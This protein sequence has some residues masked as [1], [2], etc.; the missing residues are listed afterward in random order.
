MND[1]F[2][3][4][5]RSNPGV[6]E[7]LSHARRQ[8]A[9]E[10]GL[11]AAWVLVDNA[12]AQVTYWLEQHDGTAPVSVAGGIVDAPRLL[13]SVPSSRLGNGAGLVRDSAAGAI[14]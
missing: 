7:Q 3:T 12:I 5:H 8:L 4:W 9:G 11:E 1:L 2:A 14:T 6:I 13:E 10:P